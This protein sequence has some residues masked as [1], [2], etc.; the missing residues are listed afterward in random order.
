MFR[1]LKP[2]GIA[3]HAVGPFYFSFAGDHCISD[4]GFDA[5]FDHL[6]LDD[7]TYRERINDL[8]F[9]R[10]KPDPNCNFWAVHDKFSFA[11]PAEFFSTLAP[12]FEIEHVT[13]IVSPE[14]LQYRSMYPHR[15]VELLAA[16]L[17]EE[18]LCVKSI[19]IRARRRNQA[20]VIANAMST[21][22]DT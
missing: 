18:D 12:Y 6:L 15:W 7:K 10:D 22:D 1:V 5:G 9:F 16:G 3:F 19:H 21:S 14:S 17:S 8:E 20:L 2:G 13:V 4:Y 11:T